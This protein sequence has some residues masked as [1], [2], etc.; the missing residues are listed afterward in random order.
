[1]KTKFILL[2]IASFTT[3]CVDSLDDYNVDQK[4]ASVVPASTLFSNA[5]KDLSDNFATPNVN[6]NNFRFYIQY[7]TAVTYTVE[8]RYDMTSRLIPQNFWTPFYRDALSDLK[9]SKRIIENDPL[10]IDKV[11][12]N[13]VAQTEIMSVL[14]WSSLINTFGNIPYSE[15]LD[16][17][18]TTLPKYDDMETVYAAILIRLD[19]AIAAM[20]AT[21][22]GM[23]SVSDVMY[24]GDITKWLKFGNSL[25]LRL[26]MILADKDPTKAKTLVQE[27]TSN[28]ENLI[29]S[30]EENA[31]HPYLSS[32]PNNNPISNNTIAPF[33]TRQDFV[34]S[35]TVVNK[36]NSLNDPRRPFYF[37][38]VDGAY[39]GGVNG[40]PNTYATTSHISTKV[41]APTFENLFMDYA[42]V[43]FLLAEAVERGF[44]SGVAEEFY[45]NAILGS[46]TYWGGSTT[47]AADYL[48][49]PTV[50]YTTAIGDFKQKIGEQK[51]I[52]LYN[53]G[54]DAWVEWRRLDFPQLLPVSGTGVPAGLIIPL[55]L[56]YPVSEQTQN[57]DS[58]LE[59]VSEMGGD[60]TAV[61]VF[62][63]IH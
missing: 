50:A 35:E 27:A 48:A 4:R 33:T 63:D 53:R 17:L 20:D 34:V 30:N 26:A 62:W 41:T 24:G 47:A 10:L 49:Q 36:L 31:R 40:F 6:V 22:A 15:A 7:W 12:A 19:A 3:A 8:P 14:A 56:I 23:S 29:A 43:Q 32:A 59:A 42:E 38:D 25:K 18:S 45:D 57:G 9:E 37:T 55:R 44:I 52:A 21:E 60:N 46:I 58:Y 16:P 11:K 2:L 1:M 39:V 5:L 54:Y 28:P 61:K 13:Q 51:W